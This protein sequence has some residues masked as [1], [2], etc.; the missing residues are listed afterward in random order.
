MLLQL[1]AA[2]NFGNTISQNY[3]L[4]SCTVGPH[5]HPPLSPL[6]HYLV[7]SVKSADRGPTGVQTGKTQDGIPK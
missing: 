4:K 7:L 3:L 5:F 1:M 2:Q 6:I